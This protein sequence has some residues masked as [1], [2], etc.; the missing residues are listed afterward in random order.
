[1][2]RKMTSN[3]TKYVKIVNKNNQI[4]INPIV[5]RFSNVQ[6]FLTASEI[7]SCINRGAIVSEIKGDKLT[8]LSLENYDIVEDTVVEEPTPEVT[9]EVKKEEV[10]PVVEDKTVV[11][12]EPTPEVTEE[13]EESQQPDPYENLD[14]S[15]EEE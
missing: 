1:M 7:K 8:P 9:E 14:Y 13:V 3:E 4:N 5:S 11:E 12:E 2:L 10:A 6:R 15:T